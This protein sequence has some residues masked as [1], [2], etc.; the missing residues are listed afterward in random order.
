MIKMKKFFAQFKSL[1]L[2]T[3]I[4]AALAAVLTLF[5]IFSL[6][7]KGWYD[8]LPVY[9]DLICGLTTWSGYNKQADLWLIRG[10]I[11]GL[12]L[13]FILFAWILLK[14]KPVRQNTGREEKTDREKAVYGFMIGYAAVLLMILTQ[15]RY[16]WQS[17][18]FWQA[19]V[20]LC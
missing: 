18:H 2:R 12:P 16:M 14:V 3:G 6:F 20:C 7:I 9:K 5:S 10:A 13:L 15:Q 19:V 1:D 4:E 11:I 17:E 8:Q